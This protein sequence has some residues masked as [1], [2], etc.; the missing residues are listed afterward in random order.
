MIPYRV[1]IF[2]SKGDDETQTITLGKQLET[3]ILDDADSV[4]SKQYTKLA[5]LGVL[6]GCCDNNHSARGQCPG[7]SNATD[8]TYCVLSTIT[9]ARG[10]VFTTFFK[11]HQHRR[12]YNFGNSKR[13]WVCRH[14][15][16]PPWKKFYK[17]IWK[18]ELGAWSNKLKRLR[19]PWMKRMDR[20]NVAPKNN[21]LVCV[22]ARGKSLPRHAKNQSQ[23]LEFTRLFW[24]VGVAR[25]SSLCYLLSCEMKRGK[26]HLTRYPLFC[27]W[28]MVQI[29]IQS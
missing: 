20:N 12:W 6:C 24:R 3:R 1:G 16:W 22:R 23:S 4:V 29:G 26:R 5:H 15:I 27:T 17:R 25:K 18:S 19:L 14:E 2:D 10:T 9:L 28:R 8:T 11:Q 13:A 21:G 7:G